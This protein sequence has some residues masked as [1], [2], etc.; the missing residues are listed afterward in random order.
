MDFQN[1]LSGNLPTLV[2]PNFCIIQPL[3]ELLLNSKAAILSSVSGANPIAAGVLA[4]LVKSNKSRGSRYRPV[5]RLERRQ[6]H[7]FFF[8]CIE[9]AGYAKREVYKRYAGMGE[10]S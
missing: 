7:F 5:F 9:R 3:L 6:L 4:L 1:T 8:I 2:P 10:Y